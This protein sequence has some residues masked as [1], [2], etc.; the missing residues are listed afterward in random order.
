MR[1]QSP[2]C[3]LLALCLLP[4]ALTATPDLRHGFAAAD[5]TVFPDDRLPHRFYYLPGALVIATTDDGA[6][7]L[8]L[9]STRYTGTRA[10]GDQ[11]TFLTRSIL[12]FRVRLDSPT[13]DLL[14]AA[15]KEIEASGQRRVDLRPMPILRTESVLVYAALNPETG[16]IEESTLLPGGSLEKSTGTETSGTYWRQRVLALRLG[17]QDAQLLLHAL[18]AGQVAMSLGWALLAN[19]ISSSEEFS[20]LSG[21]PELVA[22]MRERLDLENPDAEAPR[23]VVVR[24]GA[25]AVE[26]DTAKWPHLLRKIDLNSE[27]PPGYAALQIYCYD[28]RNTLTTDTFEKRIDLLAQSVAGP[29]VGLSV[30]FNSDA[31]DLY[32]HTARFSVAVRLDQP[33]KYRVREIALDGQERLVTD[34]TESH[35]WADILDITRRPAEEETDHEPSFIDS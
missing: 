20:E 22:A 9:L 30:I 35:S 19:A 12:T 33:F 29:S 17:D 10:A 11:G 23:P 2:I 5:L 26:L 13:F 28:F 8:H 24:A 16:E 1:R 14:A 32:S 34:W 31:P 3:A 27:V 7:D 21:S 18:E 25:T 6:P 15:K 4:V